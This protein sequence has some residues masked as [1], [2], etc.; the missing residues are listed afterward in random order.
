[1]TTFVLSVPPSVNAM[2]YN[3]SGKGRRKTR[4]Y[5]E[6]LKGETAAL[7]AQRAKPIEGRASVTITLPKGTR[8]DCDGRIKGTLDLLVKCGVLKDDSK[9]YLGSVTASFSASSEDQMM[10]VEIAPCS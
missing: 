5:R 9:Q 7:V 1:M 3:L 8:G 4:Q 2:Y 10:R 6:W